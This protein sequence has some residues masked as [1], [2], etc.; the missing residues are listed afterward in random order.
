M[1]PEDLKIFEKLRV[2]AIIVRVPGKVRKGKGLPTP[3]EALEIEKSLTFID[4]EANDRFVDKLMS[5]VAVGSGKKVLTLEDQREL[6]KNRYGKLRVGAVITRDP[7]KV[8]KVKRLPTPEEALEIEK[9]LKFID[10]EANDRFVD[11]LMA[12]R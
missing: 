3:E 10:P 2:G 9:S 7:R 5:E 11:L 8:R 1:N 12:T 4:P 6:V